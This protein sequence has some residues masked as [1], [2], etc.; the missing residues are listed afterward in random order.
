MRILGSTL[1]TTF[2]IS[3]SSVSCGHHVLHY[4]C[5]THLSY[6]WRFVKKV[7]FMLRIFYHN[8]KLL[9]TERKRERNAPVLLCSWGYCKDPPFPVQLRYAKG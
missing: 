4:I 1:L 9:K 8:E 5:S 2:C 6:N 7:N 3:H